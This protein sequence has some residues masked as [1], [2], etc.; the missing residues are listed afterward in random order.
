MGTKL[1]KIEGKVFRL[2]QDL[3]KMAKQYGVTRKEIENEYQFM[4][5]ITPGFKLINYN[6]AAYTAVVKRSRGKSIWE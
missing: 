1:Y 6:H 3:Y 5:K 2:D 4:M